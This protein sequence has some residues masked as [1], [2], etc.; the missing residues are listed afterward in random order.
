MINKSTPNYGAT[1]ST[2]ITNSLELCHYSWHL[3][4]TFLSIRNTSFCF[5]LS[6]CAGSLSLIYIVYCQLWVTLRL[7]NTSK[8]GHSKFLQAFSSHFLLRC[9][10]C[11]LCC[12]K[13]RHKPKILVIHQKNKMQTLKTFFKSTVSGWTSKALLKTLTIFTKP[14]V[15]V[16]V[17]L[18]SAGI[19]LFLLPSTMKYFML[20]KIKMPF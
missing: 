13:F 17:F 5:R 16:T 20:F 4:F 1:I 2:F 10:C 3:Q 9:L 18:E 12:A 11:S 14:Q 19:L 7:W 15:F 6:C 8:Q